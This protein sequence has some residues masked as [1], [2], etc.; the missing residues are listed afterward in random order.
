MHNGKCSNNKFHQETEI[1]PSLYSISGLNLNRIFPY[2]NRPKLYI[3]VISCLATSFNSF[4]SNMG[5]I[6]SN[7][8]TR[9]CLRQM[10]ED[11][12]SI[13]AD[14]VIANCVYM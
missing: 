8:R 10:Q 6:P 4:T 13:H 12:F 14:V 7:V 3:V 11:A 9:C 5:V 2:G 1:V